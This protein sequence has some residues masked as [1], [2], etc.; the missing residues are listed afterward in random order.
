M[1]TIKSIFE[2]Y[3]P[4][5]IQRFADRM[6]ADHR[7]VIDAIVNCRTD[8]YGACIYQ[9]SQCGKKHMLYRCCGNR[10]C[11]NCQHHK[12]RQWLQ[13]QLNR[14]LP[15]HHFMITFTVPQ[16]LRRFIRSHQRLCYS[17]MFTASSQTIKK[18]AP[19][20]KHI[21]ADMP[22][23]FGV[24][25]TW[26]RQMPYHP[27]IHYIV[28]GGAFSK[29]DG[30]W[31]CS[32][33]DFF[34]PVRAMSMI[35]KTKFR[36]IIKKSKL[37]PQIPTDV[38]NQNWIVNC[39]AIGASEHSIKYLAPYVF[40]VA[41]SNSRIVK[42][43]DRQVFFRYR[44]INSNRP[45]TMA[46]DVMEFMRRFLQHVL[47]TG[48][49]K[50]RYYGFLHPASSVKLDKIAAL[51]ELAFGFQIV[52]PKTV[53]DSPEPMTCKSCGA[54]MVLRVSLLPFKTVWADSG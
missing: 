4:E 22:G 36:D 18:L 12:A 52:T 29:T 33:I 44:K 10:H 2:T 31:H 5:Y 35:F 8:H 54:I 17:A 47:P 49:M 51:I 6:P 24:L 34:L 14:Q 40:K 9:C 19:D 43:E 50:I 26:G 38:W 13:T 25:H 28:P 11:P 15:G 7:K 37:Y 45:R 46:L 32:R 3:G 27:H 41:I 21:G 30:Q 39:Q 23:F 53:L 20:P 1:T 48:F 16:N 42:I